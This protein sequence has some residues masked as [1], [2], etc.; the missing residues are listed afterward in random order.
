MNL[1]KWIETDEE[2]TVDGI[3]KNRQFFFLKIFKFL[4]FFFFYFKILLKLFKQKYINIF[5]IPYFMNN[6]YQ[7]FF[8]YIQWQ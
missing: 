1:M 4:F 5:F 2:Q 8:F 6:L 3:K 7:N